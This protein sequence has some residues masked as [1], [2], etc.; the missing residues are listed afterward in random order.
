[1][2]AL[3]VVTPLDGSMPRDLGVMR[4]MDVLPAKVLRQD[5]DI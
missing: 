2:A 1:M 4:E 5:V 3:R